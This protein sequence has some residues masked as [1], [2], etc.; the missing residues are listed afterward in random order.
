ME[1]NG[2]E[3]E[4]DGKGKYQSTGVKLIDKGGGKCHGRDKKNCKG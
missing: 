1:G 3:K 2:A 4:E